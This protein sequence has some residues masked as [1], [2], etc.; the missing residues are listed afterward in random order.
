MILVE[1][2]EVEVCR[3]HCGIGLREVGSRLWAGQIGI[4]EMFRTR[5]RTRIETETATCRPE[6]GGAGAE[7]AE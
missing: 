1:G 3:S 4:T 2:D 5:N 6:S 7:E